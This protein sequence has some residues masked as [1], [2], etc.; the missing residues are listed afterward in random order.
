MYIYIKYI[1]V[2]IMYMKIYIYIYMYV[3]VYLLNILVY[4][5]VAHTENSAHYRALWIHFTNVYMYIYTH[6]H[7]YIHKCTCAFTYAFVS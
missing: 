4:V 5:P 3:C 2:H 6:K 1:C 7:T